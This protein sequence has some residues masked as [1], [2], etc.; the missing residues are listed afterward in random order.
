[1]N[2]YKYTSLFQEVV[3]EDVLDIIARR[4]ANPALTERG[5]KRFPIWAFA[6]LSIAVVKSTSTC[7]AWSLVVPVLSRKSGC[8]SLR[9]LIS[10]SSIKCQ[11]VPFWLGSF[12][13]KMRASV[14]LYWPL[15]HSTSVV[16]S[17][18]SEEKQRCCHW[19]FHFTGSSCPSCCF[20]EAAHHGALL[21]LCARR[22][23]V[24]T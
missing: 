5:R 14:V 4:L 2:K 7:A 6:S 18:F 13:C 16:L 12:S 21:H 22:A 24:H 1:M 11:A 3:G 19:E 8:L 10:C 15:T 17:P 20:A 9:D 23:V